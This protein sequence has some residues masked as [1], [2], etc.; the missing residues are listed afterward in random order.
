MDAWQ[1]DGSRQDQT[2]KTPERVPGSTTGRMIRAYRKEAKRLSRT[3]GANKSPAKIRPSQAPRANPDFPPRL[4]LLPAHQ[5]VAW[6]VLF[7]SVR[8]QQE[9]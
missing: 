9:G 1:T 2:C 3:A 8:S 4:S 7:R 5:S 6:R